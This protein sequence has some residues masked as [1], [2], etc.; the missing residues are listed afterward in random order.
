MHETVETFLS[1]KNPMLTL[2]LNNKLINQ[3]EELDYKG[4]H[5]IASEEYSFFKSLSIFGVETPWTLNHSVSAHIQWN[6]PE[7]SIG[8]YYCE[9]VGGDG[10]NPAHI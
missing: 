4:D 6:C 1:L 8:Y 10:T 5:S 2:N 3:H 7:H 9:W